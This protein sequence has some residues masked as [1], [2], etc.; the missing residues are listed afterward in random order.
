MNEAEFYQW[1]KRIQALR[2]AAGSAQLAAGGTS[3][4][5]E[6]VGLDLIA[7]FRVFDR[8]KNGFITKVNGK[9]NLPLFCFYILREKEINRFSRT[10]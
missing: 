1:V 6:E 4:V 3:S 10:S 8:D 9:S 7:A 2:P 5:D